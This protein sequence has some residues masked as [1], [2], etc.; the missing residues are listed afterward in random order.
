M[1]DGIR[2]WMTQ[3]CGFRILAI[4]A[5]EAVAEAVEKAGANPYAAVPFGS[6]LMGASLLEIATAP[7]DRIQCA[8]QHD[9][10]MGAVVADIWP[11]VTM[12]GRIETPAPDVQPVLGP[13]AVLKVSKHPMKGG[14][15]YQSSAPVPGRSLPDAFQAYC[16]Q[17]EQLLSIFNLETVMD[18]W[19]V[20]YAGG[21]IIQ[22]MP[23]AN[24]ESLERVTRCLE[25][26][27][28]SDLIRTRLTPFEAV[29]RIFD[30]TDLVLLGDDNI[31][32]KCRCSK[33]RAVQALSTLSPEEIQEIR[34]GSEET[35]TC[36]FCNTTYALTAADLD[37]FS[38]D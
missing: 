19:D 17:S 11:G 37:E 35:V 15:V 20:R 27:S 16:L 5:T 36:D 10:P 33:E 8:L 18:G 34:D 9:G 32:Y 23:E 38:A 4:Q 22:S 24:H 25:R 28:F 6:L 2:R 12:R 14:E 30:D 1:T 31:Q 21:F 26:Q 7:A 3:D 29:T 13:D